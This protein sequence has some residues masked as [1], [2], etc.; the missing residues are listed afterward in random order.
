MSD[1]P[2]YQMSHVTQKGPF[3][4]FVIKMFILL[5]TECTFFLLILIRLVC[6]NLSRI[7]DKISFRWGSKHSVYAV[8]SFSAN[9][10]S[11]Y[12]RNDMQN[13]T[14]VILYIMNIIFIAQC[15]LV[16]NYEFLH[17]SKGVL[18][19]INVVKEKAFSRKHVLTFFIAKIWR[20]FSI[21]SQLRKGPFLRDSVH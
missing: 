12:F 4:V 18:A 11:R 1:I 9:V 21:T 17:C 19:N 10:T 15:L 13:I 2:F 8:A 20:P 7:S 3:R 6:E 5:F 14:A 16:A